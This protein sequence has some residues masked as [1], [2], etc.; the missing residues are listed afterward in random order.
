MKQSR[1]KFLKITG[2]ATA[3]GAAVGYSD[4]LTA[5]ARLSR[6][7]NPAPDAIY[8]NAPAPEARIAADGQVVTNDDFTVASTVCIGC[9]TQCGVRV[10]VDN[11]SGTVVRAA[12][13]PYHPLSSDPWLPYETPLRDS[14]R[15]TSNYGESG[16]ENRST[17]CARGNVVFDKIHDK[18]RV[19]TPL[20][21]AGKR[22]EDKWIPIS[23]EQLIEEVVGGGNLFGE[24]HVDGL[25]AIRDLETLIDPDNPEYGT[26]ANQLG[27]L[28][29]ADEGR[30]DF[31]VFRFLQAF[32]S[33]NYS[34]HSSICG[35]S[36]RAGNAAFLSDFNKYPHLKPDF[37]HCEFLINFGTS[38]G[39]AGNPFKRQGKLLARA[40]SEGRLQYV[41]V[42]PML[43][44]SDS[45]AAGDRSRW[46]PIRPGGDLALA[47]GMIRWIID[48]DRHNTAYLGVPSKASMERMGE[49][50]FTNA[51]H[52]VVVAPGHRL[53]GRIL[54]ASDDEKKEDFL[55][56]DSADGS[57][58]PA[59]QVDAA[60]LEVDETLTY[61]GEELAVKSSFT[62]LK[63]SAFR[64]TL[65]EYARESGIPAEEIAGLAREFTSYGRKV[66]VDCHGNTMH[67]TGFYTTWAILSLSALVGSLNYQGGMSAG[68]GKFTD[69]KG[70]A[71]D[72]T[73]Y[74]GKPKQ[75]GIR[76][77]RTRIAYEKTSEF[78]RN[79]AAGQP[80]PAKDQ[81][82][83]FTNAIETGLITGSI[84]RYPYPLK[85]LISWNAN[86]VYGESG[87]ENTLAEALKDP[88]A[89]IPLIV[90][91]DPFI[92]ETSRLA[93]YIVPDSV[94]YET[95]G[96]LNPWGAW[97]TKTNAVRY[98]VVAPRQVAFANGEPVCMDSFVIEVGK[99]LGLPGFG[100]KAIKAADGSLH[101]L[102][103][104]EDFYLRLFENIA[105]DG[106]P[107]PDADDEE[108]RL[109]GLQDFVPRLRRVSPQS[110]RKV[111]YVMARGGRFEGKEGAYR[112]AHLAK[113]YGGM[114]SVYN[115][116][117]GTSRSAMTA[118]KYS[119]V[120]TFYGARLVKGDLL[121]KRYPRSEYP[122]TAFSFKSN[123][124][125][126]PNTA[127]S[128]LRDL[129]YTNTIDIAART[130]ESLGLAHGDAVELTS[131]GGRIEGLL[132]VREG[133]HPEAIGVEHGFGRSG[134]GAI[135]VQIGQETLEGLRFRKSGACIN[136]LGFA[137]PD[138]PGRIALSD[139]A[140]GSNSRQVI[141]V[142]IGKLPA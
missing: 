136:H 84:N 117:V 18:F 85:A 89:S 45:I 66:A 49:P 82:Y 47:M 38:P 59:D 79:Q 83:P 87:G 64:F 39:Q 17:A 44:N 100:P 122:L 40:R 128:R 107:V 67:T 98:P 65:D 118:E 113:K 106:K 62:L 123:V 3:A 70:A 104:P 13:N 8:G 134:E 61:G 131:P 68:G 81:W 112:G 137:D 119:G 12:G 35:L 69:M 16:L 31:M 141:P 127:S 37:E 125:S 11:K 57:L 43:T 86:F 4:T 2:L 73:A 96:E 139:F 93:D 76:I 101:P 126:T 129:R 140:V 41:T 108:L 135:T 92:N 7:G 114:V 94:L 99:K 9:T 80:Y 56:I 138:R 51:S 10:K 120:P 142:R 91:I 72:L 116:I 103:R 109:A 15:W 111:A 90:A 5:A 46:L 97:L 75:P 58:K 63:E 26:V 102:E 22:G 48:N 14:L 54:K 53:E 50:S 19:L 25:A 105:L 77:D 115:E 24:G 133:M 21:R 121:A 33:K 23:P 74:P 88:K 60:R 32:G 20:K 132:R 1:R 130:A 27:I 36:M 6:R 42:T 95:W 78:K 52:L 29:T 110:W 30:K 28:G 124:V 55:V 34:G 71:Y